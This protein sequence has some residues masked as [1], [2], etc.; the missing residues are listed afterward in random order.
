MSGMLW[1][2]SSSRMGLG[3]DVVFVGR[4]FGGIAARNG[5]TLTGE[6][7][8]SV[9]SRPESVSGAIAGDVADCSL[10]NYMSQL[11]NYSLADT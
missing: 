6:P 9:V 11:A 8:S 7:I 1:W 2:T 3:G 10:Q 4:A 5:A